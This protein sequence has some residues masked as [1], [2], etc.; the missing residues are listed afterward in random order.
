M[1][2]QIY[3]PGGPSQV[4]TGEAPSP[5]GGTPTTPPPGGPTYIKL[6][7]PNFNGSDNPM[8]SY[9]RIGAVEPSPYVPGQANP[10]ANGVDV[11]GEDLAAYVTGFSD[12]VRD[13]G[14]ST[15]QPATAPEALPPGDPAQAA[16]T[17]NP[18][19]DPR[20]AE[21][22]VL[23][24]K[25]GWRDHTDGNRITT[26]RGDKVEVIQG[27]YKLVVLG[28]Q[29]LQHA[30]TS[31][32]YFYDDWA[33]GVDMS[34]G[35]T[36]SLD[37]GTRAVNGVLDVEYRWQKDTDGRWGWTQITKTGVFNTSD[38]TSGPQDGQHRT[39]QGNGRQI[40]F[41]W[42]DQIM[43]ITGGPD[44]ANA[45]NTDVVLPTDSDYDGRYEP[46]A[47]GPFK[48]VDLMFNRTWANVLDEATQATT[49]RESVTAQN[50]Y[51]STTTAGSFA[52]L[53]LPGQGTDMS[54]VVLVSTT[55]SG[56]GLTAVQSSRGT[57]NVTTAT[58]STQY[59]VDPTSGAISPT[60]NNPGA[61]FGDSSL[62]NTVHSAG[63]LTNSTS[64]DGS[65]NNHTTSSD[66][67]YETTSCQSIHMS[68][69][70]APL[71]LNMAIATIIT[72]IKSI[73]HLDIHAGVHMDMHVVDHFDFHTDWHQQYKGLTNTV[74]LQDTRLTALTNYMTGQHT[75]IAG[76]A[77]LL[78]DVFNAS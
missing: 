59:A 73:V 11:T 37:Q 27:N 46:A 39:T 30:D 52:T 1:G 2:G 43:N 4:N 21:S 20:V 44:N 57:M 28:R 54:Q 31:Q 29:Q 26:T 25:G 3:D 6:L 69:D 13:R 51:T 77:T 76:M 38:V 15:A 62:N 67:I 22:Q 74:A 36:D 24:T 61:A 70:M 49:I 47:F 35:V 58:L 71:I 48:P 19:L 14:D 50:T 18:A 41:T 65:I 7:V 64:A 12:D 5:G 75:T 45:T 10:P 9:L 8:G 56:Q 55:Q 17:A 23:H 66:L 63:S 78:A 60:N 68:F 40:S 72:E 34:G 42:V 32:P 16:I 53:G 33:T